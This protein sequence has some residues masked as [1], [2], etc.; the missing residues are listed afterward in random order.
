MASRNIKGITIEIDGQ[1]KGLQDSLKGVNK[2]LRDTQKDLRDVNN[3]L[4]LDPSNMELLR[5]KQDLLGKATEDTKKKLEMEK[6]ALR[7]MQ[8]S[9]DTE[10]NQAAQDAL[11]REIIET[12]QKLQ[13]LQKEYDKCNPKIEA[14]ANKTKAAAEKTKKLSAAAGVLAGGMLANAYSA[15]KTADDINTMSKQYNVSAQELQKWSYASDL[16]DVSVED[17]AASYS[18]LE[19]QMGAGSEAFD[20]LGVSITNADGSYRDIN[21]VWQDTLTALSQIDDET[22]RDIMA[23]ELF[24]RSATN[25]AGI[26]DDGGAALAAYGQEAQDAGLIL[27]QDALDGANKFNDGIDRLKG[28]FNQ[29]MLE[30]GASLAETLVPALESL[31]TWVSSIVEWFAQLDGTTQTVILV[32]LALVAALSPTLSLISTISTALPA[33][34]AAFAALSGPVGIVIAVLAALVAAGIAVYKNWDKIKEW[35][36]KLKQ[37]LV[38]TFN[39]I[40]AKVVGVWDSIKQK[41]TTAWNNIKNAIMTPIQKA[42]DKV[43]EIIEKIKGF[44]HFDW[45]LPKLKMPHVSIQGEFSLIPPKVPKFSIEWYKKAY[46]NPVMFTSPTVMAT[47]GGLK[48][49]GDGAGAEIVMGLNKLRELVGSGG[50]NTINVYASPGMNVQQLAEEVSRAMTRAEKQRRAAI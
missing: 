10:K 20:T 23:Q 32:I 31:V 3:L 49:F 14:F 17:M 22:T 33:L 25:L 1:T 47:A 5:Q 50:G 44:F 8:E 12:E 15:A 13:G 19:K 48:G 37:S 7:Q 46:E 35:A 4:K 34:Q 36:A 26:I 18:K 29:G 27:S 38:D 40:K 16:V 39:N 6:E 30:M 9:G 42:K 2:D 45:S 41:T 21:L 28:T 11:Q 43:H 24:G